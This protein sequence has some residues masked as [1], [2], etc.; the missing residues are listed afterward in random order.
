MLLSSLE[1][2]ELVH[3]VVQRIEVGDAQISMQLDRMAIVSRLMPEA[4]SKSTARMPAVDPLVL[5]IVANLRRAG[6]GVRLVIGDGSMQAIDDSLVAL[7]ARA[8]ATREMFFASGD[9]SVESMATRLGVRRDY[10]AVQM[11]LS[12][13]APQIVRAILVGAAPVELTPTRLVALSRNLPYDWEAQ[14]RLL[15]FAPV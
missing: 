15:G 14:C 11:R 1:L 7:I 9:D 3:C 10:L 13:L 5:S 6:K 4:A 2:R 12:Y 8:I